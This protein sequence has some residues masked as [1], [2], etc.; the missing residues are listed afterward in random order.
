M[1]HNRRES[2]IVDHS[3]SA[4]PAMGDLVAISG[5][6]RLLGDWTHKAFIPA[7]LSSQEPALSG[8]TYRAVA[9]AGRALKG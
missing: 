8:A 1:S 6:D 5:S 2:D 9:A 7:P 4:N 3:M